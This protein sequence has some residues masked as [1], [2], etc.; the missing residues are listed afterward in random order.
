MRVIMIL[1]LLF[2]LMA[3]SSL[4]QMDY[5]KY[6]NSLGLEGMVVIV[7]G[8]IR[9]HHDGSIGFASTYKRIFGRLPAKEQIEKIDSNILVRIDNIEQVRSSLLDFLTIAYSNDKY[10]DVN[11][12][13]MMRYGVICYSNNHCCPAKG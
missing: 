5:K 3:S 12:Y 2:F 8:Y 1:I 9:G 13:D 4:A 10:A 7:T 6:W 11:I